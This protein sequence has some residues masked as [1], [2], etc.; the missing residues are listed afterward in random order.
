MTIYLLGLCITATI[1]QPTFKDGTLIARATAVT[2]ATAATDATAGTSVTALVEPCII[3][4][5]NSDEYLMFLIPLHFSIL[6]AWLNMFPIP[7]NG[8]S[9]AHYNR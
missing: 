1:T 9:S 4:I 2:A 3:V 6:Y 5:K 7:R 8:F